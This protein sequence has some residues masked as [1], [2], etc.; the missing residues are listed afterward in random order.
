MGYQFSVDLTAL[1]DAAAGVNEVVAEASEIRPGSMNT[2]SDVTG[3]GGL[4]NVLGDFCSRWQRG[5]QNLASDGKKVSDMLNYA[6]RAYTSYEEA[7][8]HAAS[9]NGTVSGSIPDPGMTK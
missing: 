7:T 6:Q 2:S 4:S 8:R 5:V 3:D 1:E 9:E